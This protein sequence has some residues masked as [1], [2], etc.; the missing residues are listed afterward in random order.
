MVGCTL[1]PP[2]CLAALIE[3]A[4]TRT[5]EQA[6]Q[7]TGPVRMNFLLNRVFEIDQLTEPCAR[8]NVAAMSKAD[9]DQLLSA[10]NEAVDE[11]V[12]AIRAEE[13]LATEDHSMIAMEKW[14][15]AHFREQDAQAKA[16]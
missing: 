9:L 15:D 10:Y 3:N 1:R 16:T 11:W 5:S 8:H 4:S 7:F 12:E 2:S 13:A 14:D 6:R